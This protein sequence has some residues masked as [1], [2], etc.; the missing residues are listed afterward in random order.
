ME[1]LVM[2]LHSECLLQNLFKKEDVASS[3][4]ISVLAS[5]SSWSFQETHKLQEGNSPLVL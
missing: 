4:K 5:L 1:S 2:H 3:D